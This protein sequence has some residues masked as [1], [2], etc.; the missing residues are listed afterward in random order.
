VSTESTKQATGAVT[1]EIPSRNLPP[2]TFRAM[3]NPL[4]LGRSWGPGV[5]MVGIGLAAGEFII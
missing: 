4:P 5:I 3:P 2:V 1:E